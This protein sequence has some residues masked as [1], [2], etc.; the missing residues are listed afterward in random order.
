MQ[1]Q[2]NPS[3]KKWSAIKIQC[4][5]RGLWA[6]WRVAA[7]RA[8]RREAE[9]QRSAK[10][11]EHLSR[12]NADLD[13]IGQAFRV[14]RPISERVLCAMMRQSPNFMLSG[15]APKAGRKMFG[16]I[17]VPEKLA[18]TKLQAA[19]RSVTSRRKT[20]AYRHVLQ[21]LNAVCCRP[22]HQADYLA[23]C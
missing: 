10:K 14:V 12:Y 8:A 17:M 18:A 3:L 23:E 11:A 9:A 15:D 4:F 19:W 13:K 1:V 21:K 7:I 16:G 5:M 20:H 6:R 22:C 2:C